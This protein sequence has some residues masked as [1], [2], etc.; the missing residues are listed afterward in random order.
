MSRLRR[1]LRVAGG[2]AFLVLLALGSLNLLASVILDVQKEVARRILPSDSR[3]NLPNYADKDRARQILGE[4]K[5]LQTRFVPFVDWTREPFRGQTTTIDANGQRLHP[6][7]TAQPV[8]T[9]RFFGGSTMWGSGVADDE[10]IPASFNHLHPDY[11]V[12]NHGE[13]GY[14]SRQSLDALINLVNQ[15]APMDLVVFYDGNNDVGTFC[16]PWVGIN[17]H[18]QAAKIQRLVRP[19]SY[20][21]SDLTGSIEEIGRGK[22]FSR[23]F[24]PEDPFNT[25]CHGDPAY[26]RRVAETMVN[27]WKIARAIAAV[28]GADFLAVLQPVASIGS[29]RTDHLS[30]EER[31]PNTAQNVVYPIIRELMARENADWLLDFSRVFDGDEYIFIDEC[32]V[33][34]NGNRRVAERLDEV[35]GP[36]LRRRRA[37]AGE[38]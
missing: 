9:V 23:L 1:I 14:T 18:T 25:L 3:I 21:L 24:A 2:T 32:H 29:P 34:E 37:A 17:S 11:R 12:H 19:R 31:S 8:G 10:T 27:D 35:A 22:L 16:W 13:S 28:G 30:E 33:T 4:F 7:T 15:G 20:V 38:E 36:I 26:A 5:Q 6:E